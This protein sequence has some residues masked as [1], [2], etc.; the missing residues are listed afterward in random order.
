MLACVSERKGLISE[1]IKSGTDHCRGVLPI[2]FPGALV[3][4]RQL[5]LEPDL[6]VKGAALVA[7]LLSVGSGW[8]EASKRIKRIDRA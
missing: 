7:V 3:E 1:L 5:V 8:F 2:L 4:V 6:Q